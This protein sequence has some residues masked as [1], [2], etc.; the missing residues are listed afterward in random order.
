[1]SQFIEFLGNHPLLS[2]IWVVL[3]LLIVGSW[4][5]SM[6]SS[7]KAISP[8]Q[9]TLL[10][11]RENAVV[12]DI[13]SEDDFRKGHI[14]DAKNIKQAEID[15]QKLAGLE[16][17]KDAP[18]IVVCQAGMSASKAAASLAKQGFTKVSILQGGMGAW[19]GA[20]LPVVK[21]KR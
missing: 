6:F 13:R 11:N 18:I 14:T 9:L 3:F 15:S 4:L 2:G 21:T 17:Q 12:V 1:M 19:T 5:K 7:I 20:S 8:T 16:K 10:V